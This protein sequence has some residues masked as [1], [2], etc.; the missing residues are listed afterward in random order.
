MMMM[1][2][3]DD[4]DD[5]L[6]DKDAHDDVDDVLL[7]LGYVGLITMDELG[8]VEQSIN[9]ESTVQYCP[10]FSHSEFGCFSH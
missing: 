4:D 9:E 5:G 8:S 7:V 1:M 2:I 6:I 10:F 3:D